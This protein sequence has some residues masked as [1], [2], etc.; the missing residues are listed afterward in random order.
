SDD[1][2]FSF[3]N[4]C[5]QFREFGLR[6]VHVHGE[7][8]C[9]LTSGLI[10]AQ[11]LLLYKRRLENYKILRWRG[12]HAFPVEK[13]ENATQETAFPAWEKQ[14]AV[15]EIAFPVQEKQNAAEG[16]AFAVREKQNAVQEIAFP[17]REKRNAAEGI[18]FA[19]R[20]KQNAG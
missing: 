1:N 9:R 15:Q 11:V 12:V 17:V 8:G 3:F 19:V 2:F 13:N 20:E 16:I 10:N 4:P 5:D 7:H 18:A 6:L 14:N